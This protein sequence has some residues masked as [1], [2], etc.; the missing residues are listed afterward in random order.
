MSGRAS[1]AVA[2]VLAAAVCWLAAA[3]GSRAAAGADAFGY[4]SQA[5]LWLKG[6]LRIAQPLSE[7]FPW[8]HPEESITPLGY[9]PGVARRT[10][11]PTYSP[12]TP[13]IMA[14]FDR[15]LGACGPYLVAPAFGAL[16]VF[17]TFALAW[18]LARDG[19]T[20]ALATVLMAGSP[21]FLF[22][23]M[24]PMSDT[25]TAALW[26]WT[27]VLLTWPG[28][29][30]AALAGCIASI[31]VVVRPN[32]VV[33]AGAAALAAAAWPA[34]EAPASRRA[35]RV[36]VFAAALLPGALFIAAFNYTL[37]GSP[38]LSGYGPT[39]DLYAWRFL[40]GNLTYYFGSLLE[41]E[42][43]LVAAAA[44]P[45]V[46]RRIRPA[47]LDART[48]APACAFVAIVAASYLLYL[49]FREWW[50]L[51]FF[52]PAF[53]FLFLAI[54][55]A[56]AGAG[57]ALPRRIGMTAVLLCLAVLSAYRGWF[58]TSRGVLT[59]GYGEQRY[60]AVG[61][62]IDRALPQNAVVLSMQHSGS[63]RYYSGRLTVR[64]DAFAE[65]R[66]P[67]VI[68]WFQEH[69][70]RPYILLEHWEEERY[71]ARFGNGNRFGRLELRVLAE[72]T[73]P[74][75]IRLYDSVAPVP[76]DPPPDPIAIHSRS[77]AG[78]GGIWRR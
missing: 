66:F 1:S 42:S 31:A 17:G 24:W 12:G 40:P 55:A 68:T 19:P 18:R 48:A 74:V 50:Y 41:S 26:V 34:G 73:E 58:A 7:H 47:W 64:Y 23:V 4:V 20:A 5:Y 45:L 13:L 77:C 22:N 60:V 67:S 59:F 61:Q 32:L 46:I 14:G 63:I 38:L 11:V 8:P 3:F 10:I 65:G 76:G 36:V 72:M 21:A 25:A 75:R 6:D 57:R 16:L 27:M 56:L 43:W 71:R 9:T 62:Y 70:Y 49:P 44:A 15:L 30:H 54:A 2:V 51:R 33:L 52:L 37:Y 53:P 28:I 78:P 29:A 35:L 39:G 69:G